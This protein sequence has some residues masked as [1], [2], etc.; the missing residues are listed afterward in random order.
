MKI[1]K[2]TFKVVAVYE[3]GAHI[4]E[5]IMVAYEETEQ[6]AKKQL[7]TQLAELRLTGHV[8]EMVECIDKEEM[9]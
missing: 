2:Y 6:L 9:L 7:K 5:K 3:G 1:Y 8:I 4:E